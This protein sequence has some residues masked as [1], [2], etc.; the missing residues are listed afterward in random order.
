MTGD[1]IIGMDGRQLVELRK[2]K[3]EREKREE[4][5]QK[6]NLKCEGLELR[7]GNA[8]GAYTIAHSHP[9]QPPYFNG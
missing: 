3:A 5:R 7:P 9:P 2:D 4:L 1:N 6:F 8:P